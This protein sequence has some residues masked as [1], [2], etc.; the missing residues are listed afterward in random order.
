MVTKKLNL[1]DEAWTKGIGT[2][3]YLSEDKEKSAPNMLRQLEKKKVLS[4]VEKLGLLSAAEKAGLSLSKIE[5]LGLLSTAERLGLL[6]LADEV[7]VTEPGKISSLSLP[8]IVASI[9]AAALIPHDNGLEV[10]LSYTLATVFSGVAFA[11]FVA[12][13]VIKGLQE[14]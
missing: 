1:V 4:S 7:L 9:G 10:V 13:F 2:I 6:S 5:K 8:F 3:G 12:G 14:D 11:L